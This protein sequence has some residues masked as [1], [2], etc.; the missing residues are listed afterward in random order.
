MSIDTTQNFSLYN[1]EIE[2]N[3]QNIVKKLYF[4]RLV[5]IDIVN[6]NC[7]K[8]TLLSPNKSVRTGLP[9]KSDK[10]K[11]PLATYRQHISPRIP[12]DDVDRMSRRGKYSFYKK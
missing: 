3:V 4:F 7:R 9:N 2:I 8:R 12:D 11:F 6:I 10:T 5:F 1:I